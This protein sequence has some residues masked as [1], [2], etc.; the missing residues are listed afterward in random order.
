MKKITNI[1]SW[2]DIEIVDQYRKS[3][4][5]DLVGILFKRYTRFVF[6]VCMKYLKDEEKSKDASMQIFESL[7][8][9]LLK[10]DIKNFKAWLY[11]VTKNYCLLQF[12][13]DKH[14]SV[15]EEDL[16]KVVH[17]D[18]E[19]GGF[20]YLHNENAKENKLR[21]LEDAIESLS[22][23]QKICIEL[24][25]LKEKC[26]DEVAEIT[27]YTFKQVKSYIQNGKRNLKNILQSNN[28]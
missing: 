22:K 23:E 5:N 19:S 9:G 17:D 21:K 24:F 14:R 8:T 11:S 3:N 10:H 18:V 16:K 15:F 1:E 4:N 2:P 6:L 25:Y 28:E 13:S 7:F 20:L 26:Y 12:R 27:G